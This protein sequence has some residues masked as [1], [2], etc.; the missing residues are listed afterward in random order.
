MCVCVCVVCVNVEA[1]F[2][3]DNAYANAS[4]SLSL[5]RVPFFFFYIKTPNPSLTRIL[6]N[7]PVF[8]D[9]NLKIFTRAY[10]HGLNDA[11]FVCLFFKPAF[12]DECIQCIGLFLIQLKNDNLVRLFFFFN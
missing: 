4:F 6:H 3:S 5:L 8:R 10:F 7:F 9:C 1:F 12:I 2:F 11:F